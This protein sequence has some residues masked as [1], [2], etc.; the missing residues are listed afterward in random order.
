MMFASYSV[1][2]AVRNGIP[3]VPRASWYERL[4][5]MRRAIWPLG[6]PVIIIGGIYGGIFSPTEAASVSVLYAPD[7]RAAWCSARSSSRR[8]RRSRS[9]PA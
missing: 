7:P 9:R 1:I 6:F 2:Y 4:T 5:A 8:C 3:T